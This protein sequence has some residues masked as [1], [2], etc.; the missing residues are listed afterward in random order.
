MEG[1]SFVSCDRALCIGS[2]CEFTM[3][4]GIGLLAETVRGYDPL[5]SCARVDEIVFMS[6]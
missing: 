2:K 1:A 6:A 5:F 4:F 3:S